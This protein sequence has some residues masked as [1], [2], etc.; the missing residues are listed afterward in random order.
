MLLVGVSAIYATNVCMLFSWLVNFPPIFGSGF[1]YVCLFLALPIIS[2]NLF[3]AEPEV[4]DSHLFKLLPW[5][6]LSHGETLSV[7]RAFSLRHVIRL[8]L[9]CLILIVIYWVTWFFQIR[10][11]PE[12]RNVQILTF[13]WNQDILQWL[14]GESDGVSLIKNTTDLFMTIIFEIFVFVLCV[15]LLNRNSNILHNFHQPNMRSLVFS[16]VTIL[17]LTVSF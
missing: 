13:F 5:K 3:T 6:P 9:M 11:I 12:F 1:L 16:F 10:N 14:N 15:M 8:I 7:P 2:L 4:S 17:L